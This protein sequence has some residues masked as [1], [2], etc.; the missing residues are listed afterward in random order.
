MLSVRPH[1]ISLDFKRK[2]KIILGEKGRWF[3]NDANTKAP[4]KQ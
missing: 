2:I 3:T 1:T 4:A